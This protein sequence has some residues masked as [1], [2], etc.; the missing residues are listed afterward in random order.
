MDAMRPLLWSALLVAPLLAGCTTDEGA[1]YPDRY[2][3]SDDEMPEGGQHAAFD[4][5]FQSPHEAD[6]EELQQIKKEFEAAGVGDA[7]PVALWSQ[8]I[9]FGEMDFGSFSDM[10]TTSVLRFEDNA[11]RDTAIAAIPMFG[12]ADGGPCDTTTSFEAWKADRVL[13]VVGGQ[14]PNFSVVKDALLAK[15]DD[16][17]PVELDC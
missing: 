15:A 4:D 10:V 2:L 6:E 7:A 12:G 16:L 9:I 17:E 11:D 5:D 3:L 1:G 13:V 8:V 14:E